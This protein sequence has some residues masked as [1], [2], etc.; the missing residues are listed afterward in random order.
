M[1]RSITALPATLSGPETATASVIPL[2]HW[3]LTPDSRH[4]KLFWATLQTEGAGLNT[5]SAAVLDELRQILDYL[6]RTPPAGLIIA[7]GKN[8][9]F[10]AGADIEEF[11]TLTTSEKAIALVERG[12]SL[13]NR[14]AAVPYPTLALINGVCLGGG[15]ELSLACRYRIA[16]DTPSTRLG[17]P[18]VLLGIV[19]AWGGMRRLPKLIGPQAALDMMLTAKSLDA[20]RAKKM[21]LVDLAVAPRVMH[22]SARGLV[23]SGRPTARASGMKAFMNLGLMRPM[24]AHMA[25]KQVARK[26][27]QDHY[28]APYALIDLWQKTDGDALRAPA[29][30]DQIVRSPTAS[31]LVRVFFL[32]ERLK[33]LGKVPTENTTLLAPGR[34]DTFSHA[35]T[36]IHVVGAGT[37]GGDIAAWCALRGLKVTLQDQGIE[38]IQPALAR[39][40]TLF[41]KRLRDPYARR[42]AQDRLLPDPMG[43]GIAHADLILE[44]IFEDLKAKHGLLCDI[45]K[46]A[47]PDAV[48]ASNTS[49]LRIE[50]LRSVMQRPERL[51]GVHFFNPVAMMPLVEVVGADGVDRSA[52]QRALQFVRSIDK[53]PLPVKS[54][55]GFLVNA[56][57]APYMLAAM[58]K[59][60]AGLSACD[61]DQALLDFGMPMGPLTLADTVGLDIALAAGRALAAEHPAGNADNKTPEASPDAKADGASRVNTTVP[62]C[63]QE[64]VN[65][66]H[67]G[68][69]TGQGFYIWKDGK[70]SGP[71]SLPHVQQ[72]PVS[73]N[74]RALAEELVAPL[75]NRT[76]ELV[77]SGIVADADLADAGVIFGTGFAPFR[78]GPLHWQDST[79]NSK[80]LE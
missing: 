23:L 67:L 53:L 74:A 68:K 44:A 5:L 45:E 22:D 72:A 31:N 69:K 52:L 43:H 26:A 49:S 57:L 51:V 59:V 28:P 40:Q 77:A 27:R 20:R 54:A 17:L 55:P 64:R 65:A 4:P 35:P 37:M 16:V 60:D 6:E 79:K 15:L 11:K 47:R 19:P 48:I 2:Q 66:G 78:G 24:V 9:G 63:L 46:R 50:D 10:V 42:A 14:L 32:Q 8:S 62:Q 7:S 56:V 12:W 34:A 58:R 13:F 41:A 25:R 39:A 3:I 18:E 73:A 33:G 75:V 80:G 38:R 1:T 71:G 70:A 29:L 30:L 76:R 61:I 21:G 36:H